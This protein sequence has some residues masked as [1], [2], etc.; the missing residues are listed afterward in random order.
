M[1]VLSAAG[2]SWECN[3]ASSL[4]ETLEFCLCVR[5]RTKVKPIDC[6]RL[7]ARMNFDVVQLTAKEIVVFASTIPKYSLLIRWMLVT[8]GLFWTF[9]GVPSLREHSVDELNYWDARNNNVTH[10]TGTPTS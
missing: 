8:S 6:E 9:F 4:S 10:H 1:S 3:V 7:S 5:C 2:A